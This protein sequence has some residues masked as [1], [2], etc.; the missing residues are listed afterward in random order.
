MGLRIFAIFFP[1]ISQKFSQFQKYVLGTTLPDVDDEDGEIADAQE[2]L[3]YDFSKIQTWPGFNVEIDSKYKDESQYYRLV[4]F[5]SRQ[6][7]DIL[8]MSYMNCTKVWNHKKHY[9]SHVWVENPTISSKW[10]LNFH[11]YQRIVSEKFF[12][13]S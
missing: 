10:N 11:S 7:I 4:W 3:K 13:Q 1:I 9:L 12:G 6:S 8:D 5:L 2:K